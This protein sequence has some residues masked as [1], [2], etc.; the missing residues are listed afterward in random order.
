MINDALVAF[1]G[2]GGNLSLVAGGGI[3]IPSGIIDLLGNG[4]GQAPTNIIG[5]ATVFGEDPGVGGVRPELNITIGT[6]LTGAVGQ[7]LKAALQGAIDLGATGNYQPGTWTDIA[8]QDGINL[9]NISG[10]AV[11]GAVIA[12]F[13]FLPSMPPNLRPRYL[14]LLFSPMTATALPS[15]SFTAGTISSALVTMVRDDLSNKFAARNYSV[16]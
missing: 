9:A 3:T 14:R 7:M 5:N 8:S 6:A 1:V 13:P 15:G 12:R 10:G 11:A 2:V 16:A 4:V